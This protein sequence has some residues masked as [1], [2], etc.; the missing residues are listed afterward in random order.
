MEIKYKKSGIY[1][2]KC[3]KNKKIYI[4]SAKNVYSSKRRYENAVRGSREVFQYDINGNFIKKWLS[5]KKLADILN[6]TYQNIHK[7]CNKNRNHAGGYKW[8][9]TFLGEKINHN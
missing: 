7:C 1:C 3:I 6:I 2:I 9:Y 4:G 5:M 8:L